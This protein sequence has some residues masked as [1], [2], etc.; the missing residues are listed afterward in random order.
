MNNYA[1]FYDH[2]GIFYGHFGNFCG[3]LGIFYGRLVYFTVVWCN[4]RSFGIF[5]GHFVQLFPVLVCCAKKYLSTLVAESFIPAK[6]VFS[7]QSF[8][9]WTAEKS[10]HQ[11]FGCVTAR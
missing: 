9:F 6:A 5:C 7:R 8:N 2:L 10:R 4:L 1:L 11:A 3:R